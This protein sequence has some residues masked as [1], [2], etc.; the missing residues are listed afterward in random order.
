M[1]RPMA[2]ATASI[3]GLVTLL[4]ITRSSGAARSTGVLIEVHMRTIQQAPGAPTRAASAL[5]GKYCEPTL[6]DYPRGMAKMV[7]RQDKSG[8][9]AN[10]YHETATAVTFT[11]TCRRPVP[12][13]IHG[14][15]HIVNSSSF[16]GTI[17][18]AYLM[19][20]RPVTIDAEYS[21]KSVGTC[22]YPQPTK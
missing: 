14:V 1:G 20:G 5:A 21:G 9:C 13:S 16:T 19:A 15:F 10:K 12:T 2:L 8:E 4:M 7:S 17:E 3:L 11:K 22:K 18:T 6:E